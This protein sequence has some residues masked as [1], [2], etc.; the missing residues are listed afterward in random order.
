MSNPYREVHD[1]LRARQPSGSAGLLSL[2]AVAAATPLARPV[3]L[4]FLDGPD[5]S[6]GVEAIGFR[7][8]ALVAGALALHTYTDLVRGPDRAVLDPHPVQPRNLLVAI[9]LRTARQRAMLPFMAAILVTPVAFAGHTAAFLG[10]VGIIFGAWVCG[11]GVGFT[12]HLAAV[13]SAFSPAVAGVLDALRGDNPRMQAALIYAP[14]AALAV[15]GT[16]IMLAASG[17]GAA[18]RGWAP[19]WLWLLLP[20]I[21]G[22]VG[23]AFAGPLAERWYVRASTLLAEI[24]ASWGA[25]DQGE[26]ARRVYLEWLARDPELLRALRQGWRRRRLFPMGAWG[27]GALSALAGWSADPAAGA[28]VVLVAGAGALLVASVSH[29]LAAGD[30]PWLGLALGV[31]PR[32]ATR[33]RATVAFLYAQGAILPGLLALLV[34]Q[35]GAVLA[36][37]LLI[38][39]LAV[40]AAALGATTA[41]RWGLRGG[42]AYAPLA[43]LCWGVVLTLARQ[44]TP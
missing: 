2:V 39:A 12:V 18:L 15:A 19:G 33:A 32:A 10:L 14:G 28:Q 27:L 36:P 38:E 6:L 1:I 26:E 23:A 37:A 25:T 16:T 40:V 29:S 4:G 7:L 13:W 21:V 20:P 30:P 22:V 5:V 31:K 8:G 35:G 43:L 9:A 24:D 44:V 17:V 41:A 34:R 11:L 3:L 42:L